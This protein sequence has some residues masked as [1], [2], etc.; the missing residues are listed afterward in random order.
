MPAQFNLAESTFTNRLAQNILAYFALVG[1]KPDL[2]G[3]LV[4]LYFNLV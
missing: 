1:R 2:C 4:D 3:I